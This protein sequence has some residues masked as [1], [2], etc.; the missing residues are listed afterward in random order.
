MKKTLAAMLV[1]FLFA[2]GLGISGMTQVTKV[3]GFLD[4]FGHWDP[5]LMF[6][7]AGAIGVHAFGYY[8]VRRM[9]S[10]VLDTEFHVPKKREISA[11]LVCGAFIFGVGWG[12]AGFCPGPAIVSLA[13]LDPRPAIFV[14]SMLAGMLIF[15]L[16]S[17]TRIYSPP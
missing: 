10:P 5:S 12:L 13:S 8:F 11:S 4:I 16:V 17:R 1:G 3:F 14:A 6:V 9:N 2:L 15:T 7:M